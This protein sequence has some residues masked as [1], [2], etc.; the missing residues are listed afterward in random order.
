MYDTFYRR[1]KK[2]IINDRKM[3]KCIYTTTRYRN[4]NCKKS[5]S[6][7]IYI[8]ICEMKVAFH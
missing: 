6:A 4:K 1:K 5:S 8:Y 7:K 2:K 3:L